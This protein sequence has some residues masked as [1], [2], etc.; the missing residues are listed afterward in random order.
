MSHHQPGPYAPQPMPPQQPNPWG[1]PQAYGRPQGQP[2]YGYPQQAGPYGVPPQQPQPYGWGQQPGGPGMYPPPVPPQGGGA[3]KGVAIGIGVLVLVGAIAGGGFL[4][5]A[6]R[7]GGSSSVPDDGKR[8]KLTTPDTVAG[9]FK[10]DTKDPGDGFDSGDMAELRRLG[11]ADDGTIGADYESG[12]GETGQYLQFSGAWGKVRNPERVVDGF[13]AASR[14]KQRAEG[15]GTVELI[16]TPQKMSPAGLDG[17][18]MK[19]QNAKY[20][21]AKF[22][23]GITMPICF[24]ADRS[25]VGVTILTDASAALAA[26]DVPLNVAADLTVKVRTETR[27]EVPK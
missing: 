8:Y 16:G 18:V 4:L 13:F 11:L 7:G 6:S 23:N 2:G 14:R 21:N 27:V 20:V 17:A 10:K 9:E 26:K 5:L 15:G 24:W 1:A 22:K 19:C 3:G 12:E 25:T